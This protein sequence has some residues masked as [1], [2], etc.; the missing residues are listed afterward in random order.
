MTLK[1][2]MAA[3]IESIFFNT[4]ELADNAVYNSKD[5]TIVAKAIKVIIDFGANLGQTDGGL[6][7]IVQLILKKS[8][9]DNPSIYDTITIGSVVYTVRQ[10]LNGDNYVW[11]VIT[12]AVNRDNPRS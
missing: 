4:D 1:T 7:D 3:D 2:T 6:A 8:D 10:R 11:N 9:I 5:G 12:E